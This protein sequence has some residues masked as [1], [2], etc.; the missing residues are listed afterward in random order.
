MFLQKDSFGQSIAKA[1]WEYHND[2]RD[3]W[4]HRNLRWGNINGGGACFY[5]G[6]EEVL[7]NWISWM[8][9]TAASEI[10]VQKNTMARGGKTSKKKTASKKVKK[11]T[12]KEEINMKI[13]RT[14]TA[15]AVVAAVAVS[16]FLNGCNCCKDEIA[17]DKTGTQAK[18]TPS[19]TPKP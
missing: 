8:M 5:L 7:Q 1:S 19:P 10:E 16:L 6:M 9:S 14:L 11:T 12:T 4:G 17:G 13:A 3:K 15:L 2:G 18:P